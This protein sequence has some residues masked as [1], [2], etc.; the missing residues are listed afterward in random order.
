[1]FQSA[2][3]LPLTAGDH[4]ILEVQALKV[5]TCPAVCKGALSCCQK[6]GRDFAL[7]FP[8]VGSRVHTSGHT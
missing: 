5:V 1:M 6:D 8:F 4:I 2:R 3:Y 7:K